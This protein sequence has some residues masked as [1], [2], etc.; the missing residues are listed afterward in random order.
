MVECLST[1]S[2]SLVR[3]EDDG[4]LKAP[5]YSSASPDAPPQAWLELLDGASHLVASPRRESRQSS[6]RGRPRSASRH[7]F[8]RH[9]M[10]PGMPGAHSGETLAVA[11]PRQFT[12]RGR[13]SGGCRANL[14][15]EAASVIRRI[16]RPGSH[17]Q[18]AIVESAEAAAAMA[19]A[20]MII[21]TTAGTLAVRRQA[22]A[23]SSATPALPRGQLL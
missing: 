13:R 16:Y 3:E 9:T 17:R 2:F 15:A 14:S 10:L 1:S 4:L 8:V 22:T 5:C 23:L 7:L 18:W 11:W 20:D 19:E 12:W 21:A 6:V